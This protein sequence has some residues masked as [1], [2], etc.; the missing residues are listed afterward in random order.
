MTQSEEMW[1]PKGTEREQ[2]LPEA[3]QTAGHLPQLPFHTLHSRDLCCNSYRKLPLS[4]I[5]VVA[6]SRTQTQH[7]SPSHSPVSLTHNTPFI[8]HYSAFVHTPFSAAFHVNSRLP[9]GPGV[10]L[11]ML[12][13]MI[14]ERRRRDPLSFQKRK[15]VPCK[16]NFFQVS[17]PNLDPGDWIICDKGRSKGIL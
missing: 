2:H 8:P 17:F 4:G 9:G 14:Q 5:Q 12:R 10:A 6:R 11:A 1:K 15:Q 13:R 7:S 16:L 3:P